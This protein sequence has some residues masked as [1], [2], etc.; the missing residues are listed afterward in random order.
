[1][2]S[3]ITRRTALKRIGSAGLLVGGAAVLPTW[4]AG[5]IP[6]GRPPDPDHIIP[7]P[8]GWLVLPT[9]NDD[10]DNLEWALRHTNPGGKVKL[11]AGTYKI[12]SPI[13][14]A[15]FD[16]TLAG[17]GAA[18]TTMT[19]TDLYSYELWEA[20]GSVGEPPPPFPRASVNGSLTKTP[21]E[22]IQFY[23][24][25]LQPG[26]HP[27]ERANRIEIRD[28]RCRVAMVGE[29]WAFGDEVLCFNISNSTYWLNDSAPETTR[30]D[31]VVQ[32][33]EVDGYRTEAFAPFNVA[34]ACITVVGGVITTSN[35]NL[36][37]AVDG[38]GLGFA[39]GG[40]LGVTPAEGD[41]TFRDCTFRNCRVGPGVDGY[42]DAVIQFQNVTTDHCRGNCIQLID[43]HNSRI[44]VQD[45]S[46]VCDPFV[47]P[48]EYAG[49]HEGVP[50]SL[51][52]VVAIHG[53]GAVLGYAP[54]V[55][56]WSLAYNVEAHDAHPEAGPLGTWRPSGPLEP[57][58]PTE[59]LVRANSCISSTTPNTYCIHLVDLANLAFGAQTLSAVVQRNSCEGSQTCIG[60]DHIH[61]GR[62]VDNRC[63]SQVFGVELHNTTDEIVKGNKFDFPSD[64]DG[65][66]IRILELGEKIDLSRA[67]P[68]AG[69]CMLQS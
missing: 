49:G 44:R 50:S 32:G 59:L 22:L 27:A 1:M 25:P 10:H 13:V 56:W 62:I 29:P 51:G 52:C 28:L 47:L 2:A 36:A 26:E 63:A 41:V 55:Q 40:L 66:E 9:G 46:F 57:S 33:V 23:K 8:R 11:V 37:G 64:V 45:C 5:D 60:L 65:C 6:A 18:L 35:Y 15:D 21:P 30:Q 61:A 53:M 54:N 14:V 20:D 16:G 19:C 24:T 58:D 12:G 31:V 43:I 17:A 4:A 42:R 67:A 39:N 48:S 7:R 68:E 69:V 38:D 34:C 3:S